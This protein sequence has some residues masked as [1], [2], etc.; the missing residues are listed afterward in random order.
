MGGLNRAIS[1]D[2]ILPELRQGGVAGVV[3]VQAS[4]DSRDTALMRSTAAAYSEVLGIVAWS[5]LDEPRQLASD[6]DAFEAD[7]LVVGVRNLVHEHPPEWLDRPEIERGLALLAAHRIPFDFPTA[8]PT[9]LGAL[10]GI[11]DR[12]PDLTI[13]IDHLGKPPI[14]GPPAARACWR[15][16]IAECAR[17]PRT[18]AKVS[19]LYAASGPMDA[20]T[21][22]QVRPFV[23]DAFELF[24]PS[25][26]MYGSDWPIS[27]LAGG[28]RRTWDATVELLSGASREDR[29]AVMGGTAVRVYGIDAGR[30]DRATP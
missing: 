24:G 26:L 12:H 6:L 23:D 25:R 7:P 11:G 2:E 4:D 1:L 8:D 17:N 5:P 18:V 10:P 13:V 21:V 22:D 16:V 14:G 15:R 9:A 19:G 3:L 30:M 29:D 20:W 27:Q 28:Y